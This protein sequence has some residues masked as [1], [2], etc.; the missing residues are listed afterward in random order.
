MKRVKSKLYVKSRLVKKKKRGKTSDKQEES[1]TLD[2]DSKNEDVQDD[3][4]EDRD[5]LYAV[6]ILYF[7]VLN[8]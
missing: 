1:S 7:R 8:V 2:A 4:F 5:K 3:V 6:S